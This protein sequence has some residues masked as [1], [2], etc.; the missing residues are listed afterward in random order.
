MAGL[1]RVSCS[2]AV[3]YIAFLTSN[4]PQIPPWVFVETLVKVCAAASSNIAHVLVS[5][6][7]HGPSNTLSGLC[8]FNRLRSHH[9]YIH[10]PL[11]NNNNTDLSHYFVYRL[12]YVSLNILCLDLPYHNNSQYIRLLSSQA[13]TWLPIIYCCCTYNSVRYSFVAPD[14][15]LPLL[16]VF[17]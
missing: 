13:H 9:L 7:L 12:T 17:T 3:V 4:E 16:Y 8:G 10:C 6:R 2:S 14:Y 15:Q 1:K 11:A 5:N